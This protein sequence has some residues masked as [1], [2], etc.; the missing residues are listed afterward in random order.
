M[1]SNETQRGDIP[2]GNDAVDPAFARVEALFNDASVLPKDQQ[3]SFVHSLTQ[4][5]PALRE[6]VLGM[7][8]VDNGRSTSPITHAMGAAL[9]NASRDRRQAL[10]GKVI[11]NYRLTQVL[12]HGGTGTVYLGERADRQYSAQVAVKIVDGATVHPNL[13]MRLRA[14]RQI[15][16][17]LNHQNIAKLLDA[18]EIDDDGR[19]YLIMEYVHGKP[20]DQ[21]ADDAQLDLRERL[22]LF[23]HM[24]SAVQYA[25]QNLI[26]HRD[27]KPANILVT[28]EGNPKLLDFGIAKLLDA[29]DQSAMLAMTRMND[30][31]LTPEYASPEQ[32]LG[33]V[34]TTAS[35]VYALGV[36][37]YELLTGLRPYVVPASASQLELER[38]ICVAD[39]LRPSAA[40]RRAVESSQE[41]KRSLIASLATARGLPTDRLIK[42]LIGDLDAIVLRAMRKEPD[43]RYS[44][45]EQFAADIRR[46]LNREPVQARQG[47]WMYYSARFARRNAVGVT[48]TTAFVLFLISFAVVMSVQRDRIVEERDRATQESERAERVSNFMLR[49]FTAADP[50]ENSGKQMT[51]S[52][53]LDQAASTIRG[54]LDEQPEVRARLL[55]AIGRAYRRQGQPDRAVTFLEESLRVRRRANLPEDSQTG[56]VY[57]ELAIALRNAG[58]FDESDRSFH[59]AIRVAANES[60]GKGSVTRASLLADLGRLELFRSNLDKAQDYF[61]QA[62]AMMREEKGLRD[63]DVAGIL[64]DMASV[65]SWRDDLDGAERAAREAVSIYQDSIPV[66]LHPDRVMANSRLAE[67]LFLKGRAD[68][69][70]GLYQNVLESQK[71]LYGPKSTQVAD[72]LESLGQVSLAQ[73]NLQDAEKFTREAIEVNVEAQRGDYYM[74]GYLRTSLA[75]ILT[76]LGR[77]TEA[78]PE[79]R[80]AL[81]LYARSLPTDHQYVATAEYVLGEVLLATNRLSDAEAM[82]TASMNRWKR[83]SAP[84]WRSARS[85]SA[86]GEA[87]YLEG[88]IQEAEK[89]LVQSFR[90]LN[91]DAGADLE[92]RRKARERVSRFYT[93]RGQQQKLQDLLLATNRQPDTQRG[94]A[95]N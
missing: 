23:L 77:H 80:Q 60:G 37:L 18:G 87:L 29:S 43:L 85:A 72:T 33:R 40:V 21:Y 66:K 41:D 51:A 52:E 19:P 38:S 92:T 25:H 20:V 91:A 42:R 48:V 64:L 88:H 9:D 69:A 70:G 86:L 76:R 79:L 90:D 94:V 73:G 22:E 81:D 12:G 36:V 74:T 4:D 93:E 59:E 27:L 57:S 26:V 58:R 34:V 3:A 5:D 65:R 47:N 7:L 82:L 61:T 8:A 89:Y 14:E 53:L 78:E 1:E 30:R 28:P 16:A 95:P 71:V 39:P 62:L 75:Q 63:P 68:E 35:D 15:L 46:Y 83:T 84:P 49:V 32:I 24:C 67:V 6:E 11:G 17:S 2:A 13:G 56:Q 10:L 54:E 44:S 31:L 50:F 55:E 45:V